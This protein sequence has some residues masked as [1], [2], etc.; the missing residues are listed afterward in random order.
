MRK[1][2]GEM[3]RRELLKLFGLGVGAS[4]ANRAVW[5]REVQAQ[6]TRITPRGTARNCIVIQNAGAMSPPETLDLKQTKY[7]AT[8]LDPQKIN[9]DFYLSKTLFPNYEVWAPRASLVRSLAGQPLVH[10]PAQ[11]YTQAGRPMNPAITKE[12]PAFGSVVAYELDS[13]RREDDVFPTYMSIDLWQIRCPQIGSGMLPPRF[14]GLDLNTT[15]VFDSFDGGDDSGA[16]ID[17]PSLEERWEALRRLSEVSGRSSPSLG[18]KAGQYDAHYQYAFNILQ[19]PRFSKLFNVSEEDKNRY[20]VPLDR[21]TCKL[22]LEML[23]ARNILAADAGARFVWVG[24]AAS[25]SNGSFDNHDNLYGKGDNAPV[26]AV[27]S[28]YD[29]APRLDRALSSLVEDLST[30]PGQ[31]PGKTLLDET[32]IVMCHEFGRTPHMNPA[33][34][35]DHHA[36]CYTNLFMGG[37]VKPGQIIGRTDDYCAKVVDTGWKYKQ[38]PMMDNVVS[39]IYSALGIDYSKIIEDTPSGRDYEYQQTA[40][41][42]GSDFLPLAE[43]EEL[44]V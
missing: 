15:N 19:D 13:Q 1:R 33:R 34:G 39:T 38:Q 30:M 20:G 17:V 28:I 35:R 18:E 22:G 27:L 7:T 10:L 43:I 16:A 31:E 25:G 24:N 3:S 21:M 12:I 5:P 42:G 8:D 14:A 26:G 23:L 32:L 4:F 11:Y 37:G 44:F 36:P 9:S 29:S 2:I 40:P 41:L 6:S